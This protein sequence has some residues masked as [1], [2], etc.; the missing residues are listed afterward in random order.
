ML[1]KYGVHACHHF[2]RENG[3]PEAAHRGNGEYWERGGVLPAVEHHT[4]TAQVAIRRVQ[5]IESICHAVATLVALSDECP[6]DR[7]EVRAILIG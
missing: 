7:R 3:T 5:A 6:A 4:T 2:T 1:L